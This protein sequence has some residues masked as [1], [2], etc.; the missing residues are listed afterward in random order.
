MTTRTHGTKEGTGLPSARIEKEHSNWWLWII[1]VAAAA[2]CVWFVYR[3][4]VATG[5]LITI[6][7]QSTDGLQEKNSMVTYRGAQ[8]GQVKTIRLQ[9]DNRSVKVQ[10]R[11]AG[12]AKQLARTG[13][14]FWI[15]RPQIRVGS[16]SG[17]GTIVS[18]VYIAVQPGNGP[19]TNSFVGVE[20]EPIEKE[21]GALHL[22]LVAPTI[23]SLQ[24]GSPIFYRGIQ[25]GAVLYYQLN[26]QASN[27]II[28][29]RVD[30]QYVPLVR[31]DTK[32]WNA[33]GLDIHAGLFKGIEISAES[34]KTIV[35]GGIEFATP[36]QYGPPAT[37]GTTF[38]L[39]EKPE[40][41]W[42]TW[43]PAI[44]LELTKKALETNA[45]PQFM[46]K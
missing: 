32:F 1:P 10:A 23:G 28:H 13:S 6:Y 3:D 21:P 4:Y 24:E 30:S 17:L 40:E 14:V 42:K 43:T 16:I 2:L 29:A 19:P 41:K 37:N 46:L 31:T 15:V 12:S 36:V 39:N 20:K 9:K 38:E 34:P 8:V 5:P 33:G 11:L 26:P 27:V 22:M 44:K 18:G 45:P 25:V 35:S 7:F